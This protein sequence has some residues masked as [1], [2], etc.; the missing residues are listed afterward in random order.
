MNTTLLAAWASLADALAWPAAALAIAALLRAP[1]TTLMTQVVQRA[2]SVSF[3][4]LSLDLA[5]L[6][7]FTPDWSSA[8]GDM[9]GLSD[10]QLSDSNTPSLFARLRAPSEAEVAIA[11]LEDG[12][13]WLTSRLYVFAALFDGLGGQR[14]FAF[15]ATAPDG[16][17]R[18]VG[19]ATPRAIAARLARAHPHLEAALREALCAMLPGRALAAAQEPDLVAIAQDYLKRLQQ[20]AAAGPP[21]QGWVAS[22]DGQRWEQAEWLSPRRLQA[23]LGDDLA[24][25]AVER[26][27]ETDPAAAA[28][29]AEGP[30][31]ALLERGRL[32]ALLDRFD[33]L[34]RAA[35]QS[36]RRG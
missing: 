19:A 5:P 31:V 18:Y 16:A 30:F 34:D 14:A 35:R 3:A 22:R 21:P 8:G 26:S 11:D 25:A 15:V 9:R 28:L 1:L 4:S 2:T 24:A 32:R 27:G 6:S 13:A 17:Q 20:P 7:G 36:L 10:A 29:A 23:L 33:L 12:E